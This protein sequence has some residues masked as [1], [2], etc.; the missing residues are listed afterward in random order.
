VLYVS[1][2]DDA[3]VI[4]RRAHYA[5]K[6]LPA[7][8]QKIAAADFYAIP[9]HGEVNICRNERGYGVTITP[10]FNDLRDLL[11][12]VQPTLLILDTLSRFSGIEENDNPAMTAFCGILENLI[13]EF[14]CNIILTHHSNKT[15][16]DC[17]EDKK[18]LGHALTQTAMR[19]ASALAG[20][21]RWALLMAPLGMNLAAKLIGDHAR[22]SADGSF[23]ACR[24]AKKNA[25]APEQRHYLGRDEHGLLYRVELTGQVKEDAEADARRL[26]EEIMH[27]EKTGEDRLSVSRSGQ[28]AFSWGAART[29]RAVEKG[30]LLGLFSK[31]RAGRGEHLC[32]V[33][34]ECSD[35]SGT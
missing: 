32:S 28:A 30:L 26:A 20:C 34:S 5:L 14:K 1:A 10:H 19:G 25:G 18:E 4:H 13:A 27:R 9:V 8:M 29:G 15:A 7:D 2:E 12:K 31:I 11:V 16:G 3:V 17:V 33:C 23:L 21:V 22:G 6:R 35:T 24:V